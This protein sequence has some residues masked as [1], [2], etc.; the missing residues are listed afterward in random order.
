MSAFTP[1]PW[2]A[3][4]VGT[5]LRGNLFDIEA[6]GRVLADAVHEDDAR[7]IAAAPELLEALKG[8]LHD[9]GGSIAVSRSNE[10]AVR[11]QAAIAKAEGL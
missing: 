1:G 10:K 8:L 3:V 4:F 9:D 2:K 11:A 7:L 5:N 6:G